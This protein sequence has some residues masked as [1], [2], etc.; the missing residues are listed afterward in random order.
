MIYKTC[1][2]CG[3]EYFLFDETSPDPHVCLPKFTCCFTE[4]YDEDT[5]ELECSRD[6]YK[7]DA[8]SAAEKFMEMQS[9]TDDLIGE[10][11]VVVRSEDGKVFLWTVYGEPRIEFS[12]GKH[13]DIGK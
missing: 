3:Q 7:I 10:N 5:G 9:L 6:I 12:A 2:I 11:E 8:D 13:R 1:A 4:S